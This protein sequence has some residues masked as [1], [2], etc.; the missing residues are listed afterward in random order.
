M[1]PDN[2]DFARR[3]IRTED[4]FETIVSTGGASIDPIEANYA[5]TGSVSSLWWSWR[6]PFSGPVT[7]TANSVAVPSQIGVFTGDSLTNLVAI[8]RS[9][10]T[11]ATNAQVVFS[12]VQGVYYQIALFAQGEEGALTLR[13][14]LQGLHL[15]SPLSGSIHRMPATLSLRAQLDVSG[16]SVQTMYYFANSALIGSNSVTPFGVDWMV[17]SSGTYALT[18][19]ARTSA[20]RTFS[21]LPV[22]IL[23]FDDGAELPTTRLFSGPTANCSYVI[24]SVGALYVF[25]APSAQFGFGPNGGLTTPQLAKWPQG[26]TGWKAITAV[27]SGASSYAWAVS[28]SGELYSNGIVRM[29]FPP[30]VSR[31]ERLFGGGNWE[32]SLRRRGF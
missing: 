29:E 17:P 28:Q 22:T 27:N 6:A 31:W 25:G 21:S 26:V 1:Q 5:P 13:L 32:T 19:K 11:W 12:A 7:I 9:S 14:S 20:S 4:Y 2:T 30:G 15:L 16:E 24:N 18:A 8:A 23:G 3:V 10:A